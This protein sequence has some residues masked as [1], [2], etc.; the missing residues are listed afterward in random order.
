M[1]D[2]YAFL[3]REVITFYLLNCDTCKPRIQKYGPIQAK[4]RQNNNTNCR[5]SS[6]LTTCSSPNEEEPPPTNH[7]EFTTK[8]NYESAQSQPSHYPL[9]VK[10]DNTAQQENELEDEIIDPV[11]DDGFDD[12]STNSLLSSSS[13]FTD[14]CQH[15]TTSLFQKH[16]TSLPYDQQQSQR[17][18]RNRHLPYSY[19]TPIR[20]DDLGLTRANNHLYPSSPLLSSSQ[21]PKHY[22]FYRRSLDTDFAERHGLVDTRNHQ[23]FTNTA[24]HN[25]L[26]YEQIRYPTFRYSLNTRV[27]MHNKKAEF[28]PAKTNR[29]IYPG[30]LIKE[31]NLY[32][33]HLNTPTYS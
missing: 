32:D 3:P 9:N 2:T 14:R 18:Q 20:N 29:V 26:I 11:G 17:Y 1:S 21:Y 13:L 19:T 6:T 22:D 33:D 5:P 25:D 23:R 28:Y 24:H 27:M 8:A 15:S 12:N 16:E 7:I 30:G 4:I 31:R 10:D